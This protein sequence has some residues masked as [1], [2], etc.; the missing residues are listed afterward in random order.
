MSVINIK[1]ELLEKYANE[2]KNL[3]LSLVKTETENSNNGKMAYYNDG[4]LSILDYKSTYGKPGECQ[5]NIPQL[6]NKLIENSYF[7]FQN[8]ADKER[9]LDEKLARSLR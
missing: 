7:L 4:I 6:L 8:T 9:E 5:D 2:I 1:Y 3:E